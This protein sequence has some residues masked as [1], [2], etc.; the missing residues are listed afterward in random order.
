MKVKFDAPPQPANSTLVEGKVELFPDSGFERALR[1]LNGFDR[2]WLIWWFHRNRTWRPLVR[3]PRGDGSKRG[4]FAT[5]SPHRP[6]PVGI[7]SVPLLGIAGL[8]LRVGETDLLDGTPILDIKPYISK[9]DA[10]PESKSGWLAAVEAELAK[11]PQFKVLLSELMTSQ[12][13]WLRSEF[14][15]DFISRAT[16]LLERDPR[17]HRTRRITRFGPSKFRMGCGPWRIIF[18]VRGQ[19]VLIERVAC[20]YPLRLLQK[21]GMNMIPDAEAQLAFGS[22]WPEM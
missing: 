2:I 1:D 10:F 3:P 18:S 14:G 19:T 17:P 12:V 8:E 16:E 15:V 20:G 6:N 22:R 9:V 5:R 13:E 4:V 11:P 21:E 7:S